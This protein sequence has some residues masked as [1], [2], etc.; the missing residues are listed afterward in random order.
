MQ[1]IVG[2]PIC[3]IGFALK[4]ER[5]LSA[6]LSGTIA[7]NP[8][9]DST[10]TSTANAATSSHRSRTIPRRQRRQRPCDLDGVQHPRPAQD[11][12]EVQQRPAPCQVVPTLGRDHA[13]GAGLA[14][15]ADLPDVSLL[16]RRRSRQ[17][18]MLPICAVPARKHSSSSL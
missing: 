17:T 6:E 3:S 12:P 9:H 16:W 13:G 4:A 8:T 1:I 11:G 5:R 18:R 7:Q 14:D 2:E 15:G 10:T